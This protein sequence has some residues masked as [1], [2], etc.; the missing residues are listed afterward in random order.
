[1]SRLIF[2][3]AIAVVGW[4]LYKLYFKKLLAQGQMGKIKIGM[5]VFGLIFLVLAVAG[6]APPIM[7]LVGAA[8]TQVMRLVP[9]ALRFAPMIQQM[10][11][12]KKV[13]GGSDGNTS[14]VRTQTLVMTLDHD[15]GEMHGDII[16]GPMEGRQLDQLSAAEMRVFY[17]HCNQHDTEAVRLLEAY[18]ARVQPEGWTNQ[19]HEQASGGH[20]SGNAADSSAAIGVQEAYEILGLD[21]NAS[22]DEVVD[23]HRRLMT[24]MHPDKGGSNY[25][26]A[27]INAAKQTLLETLN[28]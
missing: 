5:I 23:A 6:K 4:L 9:L 3:I 28:S 15:S 14:T 18:L 25:L 7:A 2:I 11:N 17:E 12:N 1:M 19:Q 10:I 21:R 8:M 22:A 24:R 20:S 13:F 27:K 16:A 26:A